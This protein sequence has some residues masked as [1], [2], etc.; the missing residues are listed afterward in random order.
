MD[1]KLIHALSPN[2]YRTPSESLKS[3]DYISRVGN[4]G[5]LERVA[6]KYFGAISMYFLSKL[7]KKKYK[8]KEDVR[9]SL[10]E[11]CNQWLEGIGKHRKF[12]GG[13]EPN[14]SDLVSHLSEPRT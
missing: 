6:A 11:F 2:I 8:L 9:Q 14:L 7:L 4:F 1:D 10:Y 5:V 12:M 3:F 13:S